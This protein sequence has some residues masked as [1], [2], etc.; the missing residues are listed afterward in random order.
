MTNLTDE[1]YIATINTPDNVLAA[2][3]TS[4]TYQTGAPRMVFLSM[5]MKY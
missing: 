3:T 4:S 2:S 5:T 1:K